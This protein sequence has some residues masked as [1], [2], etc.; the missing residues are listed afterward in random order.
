M[1]MAALRTTAQGNRIEVELVHDF[2]R[3]ALT[4]DAI[5]DPVF[6]L[7][8]EHM[9]GGRSHPSAVADA[10]KPFIDEVLGA[11]TVEDWQT[12]GDE[13]IEDARTVLGY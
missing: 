3:C 2:L 6:E 1:A 5:A 4:H 11:A 10:L 7:L 9:V 13:L 8:C 12:V